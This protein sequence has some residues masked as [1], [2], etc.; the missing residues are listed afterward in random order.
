MAAREGDVPAQ[1]FAKC[2]ITQPEI[3]GRNL[4]QNGNFE[5]LLNDWYRDPTW[6]LPMVAKDENEIASSLNVAADGTEDWRVVLQTVELQ[7]NTPYMFEMDIKSTAPLVA[8]YWQSDDFT[9]YLEEGN[10]YPDWT[11]LQVVFI[12]PHW[13]G[14]PRP[15]QIYP[16]LLK[17]AGTVSLKQVRLAQLQVAVP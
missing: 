6:R 15:V 16:F 7:P 10:T 11:H 3:I 1:A 5:H 17:G 4:L 2:L 9:G 14:Q 8:L 13:D 12:T